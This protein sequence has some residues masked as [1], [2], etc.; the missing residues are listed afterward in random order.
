MPGKLCTLEIYLKAMLAAVLLLN[1]AAWAREETS[2]DYFAIQVV[3]RRTGRGVPLVEL[4][5][6]NNIRLYTDSNGIVA[7]REP[8][9]TDMDVFFFVE[10]HG[11][12]FPKD[13]FGFRGTRLRTTPGGSAVIKIDRMNIAER[14][15]RVTGQGIYRDS[16]LTGWPVPLKNPVLSGQVVG[17]DSVD[18]CLHNGK[19]YWFWGDTGRPSYPLGHFA[20]AGAISDLPERGGLDPA[21]GVDLTYFVDENG[22]SRPLCRLKEPGLVWLDGFVVVPDN[23]GDERIVAKYARLKNLGHVLERGLVAFNDETESFEPVARSG[24]ECLPYSDSGHTLKANAAG[25]EYFYFATPF[26]LAV[27]MRVR[28][29][30]EDIVDPNRYEALTG[31]GA[32]RARWVSFGALTEGEGPTRTSV[33][34]ALKKEKENTHFYDME[35]GRSITPH[36]GSVHYNRFRRKWVAI[37]V[38]YGGDSSFLGEVWYAEADT[39]AGPWAYARKVATHDKYSFY[40]PMHHVRF[41]QNGGREI[42]FEGTY[43]QTFSGS[44]ETATPRYDYNQIMYRLNLDDP[45]LVLPMAVYRVEDES[46]QV[47]YLLG[48]EVERRDTWSL[49]ES[50]PFYAIEPDRASGDLMPVY[51]SGGILST[52]RPSPSALPLFCGLR[53]DTGNSENECVV[54]LYEYWQTDSDRHL[55]R[56]DG[57]LNREGWVRSKA[58]LCHVWKALPR[59]LLIDREAKPVTE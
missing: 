57:E 54:P 5:T 48:D 44:P 18:T 37:F 47:T 38:Q 1:S 53:A 24:V 25:Q 4:R 52:E 16:V 6:V 21:V 15:Y 20:M 22:F 33:I 55:Y 3:D 26:P 51:A 2:G 17:Q 12:E 29:R 58:P 23:E 41:D 19:L 7:F 32:A 40:N 30:W 9:L 11:Y 36:G 56:T 10:S 50:V 34:E 28:A 39:P 45:R 42:F 46:E 43:S 13:G 14:L 27:R 35:T 59:P 49:I 31:L 8:G